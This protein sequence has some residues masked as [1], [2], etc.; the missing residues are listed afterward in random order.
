MTRPELHAH[1]PRQT[2]R[3]RAALVV[4]EVL[5]RMPRSLA[6]RE[7]RLT[8]LGEYPFGERSGWPYRAW[9]EEVR[10][11]L[12]GEPLPSRGP[13]SSQTAARLRAAARARALAAGLAVDHPGQ[14]V[15][16]VEHGATKAPTEPATEPPAVEPPAPA[17]PAPAK[18][19]SWGL[20]PAPLQL[21]ERFPGEDH[22]HFASPPRAASFPWHKP[23]CA[24]VTPPVLELEPETGS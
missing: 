4:R 14:V 19:I 24:R 17:L 12:A 16:F 2:W 5:E 13:G 7:R 23:P 18:R 10:A 21:P 22:E 6:P 20:N 8:L 11:A 9:L 3:Q 1:E 15:A